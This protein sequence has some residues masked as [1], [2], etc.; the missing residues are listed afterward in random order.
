VTAPPVLDKTSSV[1]GIA[2]RVTR[3][4]ADGTAVT[5]LKGA[6]VMN[7]FISMS[8][9]SVYS[10]G[11]KIEQQLANGNFA[12]TYQTSDVFQ[13]IEATIMIAGPDPEFNEI[14][15]G[16]TVLLDTA[17]STVG[18]Q[19][20]ATGQIDQPNGCALEVWSYAISG[21]RQAVN[22]PYYHWMFPRLFLH[23]STGD[24][25]LENAVLGWDCDGWG[26]ANPAF[27]GTGAEDWTW[28]T[29]RPY[30]Y[31]RCAAAPLNVNAYEVV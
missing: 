18:W 14:A 21:G 13:H 15:L 27:G 12:V 28:A 11:T 30:Q 6:Y 29:D 9:K 3:L 2:M 17:G 4:N 16:G 8:F 26:N 22:L 5:G 20:T 19:P 25:K 7:R 24:K 1:Q 23:P 31:A 10:G